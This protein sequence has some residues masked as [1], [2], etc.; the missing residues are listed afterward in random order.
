MMESTASTLLTVAGHGLWGSALILGVTW[1][2]LKALDRV[3]PLNATTRHSIW[4]AGL[5]GM[6]VLHVAL[7]GGAYG[8]VVTDAGV[9]SPSIA[10]DATYETEAVAAGVTLAPSTATPVAVPTG[11]VATPR[12]ADAPASESVARD[13]FSLRLPPLAAPFAMGLGL[14]WLLGLLVGA[15]HLVVGTVSVLVLKSRAQVLSEDEHHRILSGLS[16]RSRDVQIGLADVDSPAAAGFFRP[17]VLMPP[18][19]FRE[20]D[21]DTFHQIVLHEVAHLE[22]RDDWALLLQRVVEAALWFNPAVRSVGRRLEAEREVAC[23]EWVVSQTHEPVAYAR[24]LGR[25]IELR[26]LG[27]ALTAAPGLA[28][29]EADIV[30]RVRSLLEQGLTATSRG[31]RG[32]TAIA[33]GLIALVAALTVLGA[34]KFNVSWDDHDHQKVVQTVGLT[35]PLPPLAP[36]PPLPPLASES[37]APARADAPMP[38]E[39]A[40]SAVPEPEIPE[41][42]EAP[43]TPPPAPRTEQVQLA[44]PA[45]LP[46]AGIA[47]L[48][49]S[50]SVARVLPPASAEAA[51]PADLTTAGW[52]RILKVASTIA[53]SGDRA[54]FLLE[55]AP[56]LP[57]TEAVQQAFLGTVASIS[58]SEE[59]KRVFL[60]FLQVQSPTQAVMDELIRS[61]RSIASSGDRATVLIAI[62][63][64]EHLTAESR[65][66]LA[67]AAEALSSSS[68]RA[69]V[70]RA[71]ID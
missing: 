52:L 25:M 19:L 27:S 2:A 12:V 64:S 60:R 21:M 70:L 31:L 34:P 53:S 49:L 26:L 15:W 9:V 28:A 62:A 33:V 6:V 32:Q 51:Q 54:R 67:D 41:V 17:M 35:Q 66:V 44:V 43:E 56:K 11:E 23:D 4:G 63:R 38:A 13:A 68:D 22:R 71:I 3:Q 24:S 42:P 20:G 40:A 48:E 29:R 65:T 18:S 5:A 30:N 47:P 55:A 58:S 37:P 57:A 7:L 36:L 1:L 46:A 14:V 59:Q 10:A 61:A 8:P 45:A 69:R 39:P 50:T 16:R